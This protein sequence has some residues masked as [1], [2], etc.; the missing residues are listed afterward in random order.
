MK[1]PQRPILRRITVLVV[2]LL[3]FGLSS[4]FQLFWTVRAQTDE[5]SNVT[6]SASDQLETVGQ[7]LGSCDQAYLN[8]LP[9]PKVNKDQQLHRVIQLVNCSNQA[10]LGAANAAQKDS[11]KGLVSVL[12]REDT[13]VM[14]PITGPPGDNIL[15]IDI[16]RAWEDTKCK[17]GDPNCTGLGIVGPRFWART[18]CSISRAFDRAQ[19]ETGGCGGRYDCSAARLSSTGPT[20]VS[21]WTLYEEV[22]NAN[23]SYFKD[24]PDI[25]AVDGVNLNMDIQPLG[26]QDKDDPFDQDGGHDPQWLYRNYPLTLHGADMRS[27]GRCPPAFRLKRS[28]LAFVQVD[29]T[30]KPVGGDNTIA[31]FS[32]CGK[33]AYPIAPQINCPEDSDPTS[34]CHRWKVFCAGDPSKYWKL[35]TATCNYD[36]NQ[37]NVPPGPANYYLASCW[38]Q[39][40]KPP[41]PPVNS[42]PDNHCNLRAIQTKPNCP[43]GV[44]MDN[45]CPDDQCTFPYGYLDKKLNPNQNLYGFQPPPGLCSQ[46]PLASGE[47]VEDVCIGDDTMHAVMH[48]VYTWPNDPQVFGGDA[49]VYR[50]IFAPGGTRRPITET[51]SIPFCQNLP[52]NVYNTKHWWDVGTQTGLCQFQIQHGALFAQAKTK[53]SQKDWDCDLTDPTSE[54]KDGPMCKWQ[55]ATI[56]RQFGIKIQHVGLRLNFNSAGSSLSVNKFRFG[57]S[58]KTPKTRVRAL[59]MATCCLRRLRLRQ[60]AQTRRLR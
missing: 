58:L 10:L 8:S 37:C 56:I 12:P 52:D 13:W 46:L 34:Q 32:N 4:V 17:T 44:K 11:G 43:P 30:G 57:K 1:N 15:T 21:E 35:N 14:E 48:K 7:D 36:D 9:V 47:K 33:Y 24:S 22:K 25:S 41:K 49:E 55:S 16:P 42:T 54:A 23:R 5:A 60:Q 18:G 29:G 27:D 39:K 40:L 19:C 3:A 53:S 45:C 51:R 59:R 31:C 2:A 28:Q 26:K 6:N 38:D 20:T 50:V